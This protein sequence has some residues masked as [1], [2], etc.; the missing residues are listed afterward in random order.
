MCFRSCSISTSY[1]CNSCNFQY[2]I[3]GWPTLVLA[4]LIHNLCI[5]VSILFFTQA[6]QHDFLYGVQY[7]WNLV[8]FTMVMAFS[9]NTPI[10]VPFG[11]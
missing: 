9:L 10:I 2:L 4:P 5:K 1:L 3:L 7:A 11:E 8:I 6:S